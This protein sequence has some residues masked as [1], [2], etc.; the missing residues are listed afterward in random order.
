MFNMSCVT[1]HLLRPR[2]TPNDA[3][4]ECFISSILILQTNL[5]YEAYISFYRA[6]MFGGLDVL[7]VR[8][9]RFF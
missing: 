5:E 3:E 9:T 6:V 4:T 8:K 1:F 2:R 7:F